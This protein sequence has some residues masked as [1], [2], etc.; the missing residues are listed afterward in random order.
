[1]TW[2]SPFSLPGHWFKGNL[3]THT[4]Q[5]DGDATPQQAAGWYGDHGYDFVSLTDHQVHTPGGVYARHD[6]LTLTGVEL[7]GDGYHLI[8]LGCSAL[9]DLAAQATPQGC[10]D[11]V[12]ALGGLPFFA[13]PYWCA[14]TPE[15]IAPIRGVLGLEVYNS[16][17]ERMDGLGVAS[18]YWDAVLGQGKR[19]WGLAVDDAHWR[20]NEVGVGFVM[21]RAPALS[22]PAILDALRQGQFYA[23]TGPKIQ[24]LRLVPDGSGQPALRV[25]CDPCETITFY[26]H[27][28]RGRRVYAAPGELLDAATCTLRRDQVFLRVECRDAQGR[29]AWS[30]P[31]FVE[32]VL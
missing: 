1:M 11:A 27:G 12:T 9:P 25:T 10:V 22:E 31:L 17:C 24:D 20:H 6:L 29:T 16:V 7:A 5:S 15:Q 8:A 30:N 3:H 28:N 32:D 23:S 21:V 4:K 14:Q 18:A 2:T 13:H 26:A 19:L